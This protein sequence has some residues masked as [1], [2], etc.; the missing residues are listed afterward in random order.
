MTIEINESEIFAALDRIR[1][2]PER[3]LTEL[4]Y[5][6]LGSGRTV[7]PLV[8]W[9]KLTQFFNDI[10]QTNYSVKTLQNKYNAYNRCHN[11]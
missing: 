2:T 3:G 6:V 8:Q 10:F 11:D 4:Q 7:T 5:K 9:N 1:Q